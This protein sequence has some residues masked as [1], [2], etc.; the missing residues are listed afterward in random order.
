MDAVHLPL[1]GMPLV[2][3]LPHTV[4]LI[5]YECTLKGI[6]KRCGGRCCSSPSFWPP[7]SGPNHTCVHLGPQGCTIGND[8]PVT[9]HLYPL[10]IKDTTLF[11]HG[12]T[13][14]PAVCK[15][16]RGADDAPPLIDSIRSGLIAIF[17][18]AEVVA[19]R[20]DVMAGRDAYLRVPAWVPAALE[21]ED[22]LEAANV[23]P[24]AVDPLRPHPVVQ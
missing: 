22:A 24:P 17:G 19:A 5:R 4:A 16:N 13:R 6:L 21:A 9:C 12:A 8:R 18:E 11:I 15:G 10:R 2:W 3:R 23:P 14:W 1:P 20:A 7:K